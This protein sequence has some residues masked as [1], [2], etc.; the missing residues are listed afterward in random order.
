MDFKLDQATKALANATAS[1][2]TTLSADPSTAASASIEKAI[3][4]LALAAEC[5]PLN[6]AQSSEGD[7]KP[8][9]RSLDRFMLSLLSLISSK[10][11]PSLPKETQ[12]LS[13]SLV[14]LSSP[15]FRYSRIPVFHVLCSQIKDSQDL[16]ALSRIL[17][18]IKK[19]LTQQ[20]IL[21][22][23]IDCIGDRIKWNQFTAI[24][25]VLPD[26]ISNASSGRF[27]DPFFEFRAFSNYILKDTC[28]T[29]SV[30]VDLASNA[31]TEME[32][33][34][35]FI[36]ILWTKLCRLGY[37]KNLAHLLVHYTLKSWS[38]QSPQF[39]SEIMSQILLMIDIDQLQKVVPC[40]IHELS[41]LHD[42][43]SA[44]KMTQV[45]FKLIPSDKITSSVT[46]QSLFRDFTKLIKASHL[47]IRIMLK[48]FSTFEKEFALSVESSLLE[49]VSLWASPSFCQ[50]SLESDHYN[51]TCAILM[52]LG[53][54]K[55]SV[56][57]GP[58]GMIGKSSTTSWE[59]KLETL[60]MK[61]VQQHLSSTSPVK[62]TR[63]M[64]LGECVMAKLRPDVPLTFDLAD[65]DST[66][67]ITF[68]KSL[69]AI[70]PNDSIAA[71]KTETGSSHAQNESSASVDQDLE[72]SDES[73]EDD[74]DDDLTPLP[75][76][77]S[78]VNSKIP[79]Y[80]RDCVTNLRAEDP[81]IQE[82]TLHA[83]P[84]IITRADHGD[85]ID[86]FPTLGRQLLDL[87]NPYEVK[88]FDLFL[89][90]S[91]V[92]LGVRVPKL[93]ARMLVDTLVAD[94]RGLMGRLT[95]LRYIS[96]IVTVG[97]KRGGMVPEKANA[98]V[99]KSSQE[100]SFISCVPDFYFPLVD[101]FPFL[102]SLYDTNQLAHNAL[103]ESFLKTA[104]LVLKCSENSVHSL[105]MAREL[106]DILPS[107]PYASQ[108]S[109]TRDSILL[110]FNIILSVVPPV[111]FLDEMGGP[112]SVA[113]VLRYLSGIRGVENDEERVAKTEFIEVKM[114]A[115]VN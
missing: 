8:S 12:E 82:S 34:I 31:F 20:S 96:F 1:N 51:L 39:G 94:E 46:I 93:M 90:E 28:K 66:Q 56:L 33:C 84:N 67:E 110:G 9:P 114:G 35:P 80:L 14:L 32:S 63:G 54:V 79:I 15:Q 107:I 95:V 40:I 47:E 44:S 58:G 10:L 50:K 42:R 17:S 21:D 78:R 70:P 59:Q 16:T 5:F 29:L 81:E 45:L 104:A 38:N 11:W 88:D 30:A 103:V 91:V 64:V 13:T 69:T 112:D 106:F 115:F 2:Q 61:G 36:S 98:L 62:R 99:K 111:L 87:Q 27:A 97:M 113:K 73:S 3:D 53:Y 101:N 43:C 108:D 7:W 65:S 109:N 4:A 26:K 68:L 48:T 83:L 102:F 22:L 105:R 77:D 24:I 18:L 75:Q 92:C 100:T 60:L 37:Y 52:A 85:L 23:A 49:L 6:K 74:D 76:S 71:P 55:I 72:V 86:L 19:L 41:L 89:Q 25:C 57:T